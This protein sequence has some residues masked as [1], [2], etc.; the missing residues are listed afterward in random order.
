MVSEHMNN[1]HPPSISSI[2]SQRR[3]FLYSWSF[4][5]SHSIRDLL[6]SHHKNAAIKTMAHHW[7]FQQEQKARGWLIIYFG[8]SKDFLRIRGS[9]SITICDFLK[10]CTSFHQILPQSSIF[11]IFSWNLVWEIQD[12]GTL[13][14]LG[15]YH[16]LEIILAPRV[17]TITAWEGRLAPFL[18][19]TEI[20]SQI[21]GF[22]SLN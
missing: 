5:K 14:N 20:Q 4:F 21:Y 22:F 9:P 19:Q 18:L 7:S 15:V 10:F 1:H 13:D 8:F 12:L 11:R 2:Q 6:H 17:Q 3:W 16:S